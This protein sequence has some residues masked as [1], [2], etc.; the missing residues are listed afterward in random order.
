MN[1]LVTVVLL[2]SLASTSLALKCWNT[3]GYKAM[4]DTNVLSI[5][6]ET[7][8][9]NTLIPGHHDEGLHERRREVVL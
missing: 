5:M 2:C 8:N 7:E 6:G 3:D 4:R 1:T 9:K